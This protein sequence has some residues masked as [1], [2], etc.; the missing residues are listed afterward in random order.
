MLRELETAFRAGALAGETAAAT[1]LVREDGIPAGDRIAVYTNNIVGSLIE[2]L[3]NTFPAI[4]RHVGEENFAVAAGAFVRAHPPARP[5]LDLFGAEFAAFLDGFEPARE[6]LP[7]LPDVARLEWACHDSYFAPDAPRF[8]PAALGDAGPDDY[9]GLTFAPHPATR[10]VASAYPVHAI[11]QAGSLAEVGETGYQA[12]VARPELD[13]AAHDTDAG[14][15]LLFTALA[16]GQ[17]LGDAAM[18]AQVEDD[19]FDLQGAL[20]RLIEWGV[21]RAA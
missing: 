14:T 21:F 18:V 13:V 12:I 1:A 2:V 7:W 4:R 16:A 9:L 20:V 19:D 17:T 3:E 8:D 5:Q 10:A 11:W 15:Y 6:N